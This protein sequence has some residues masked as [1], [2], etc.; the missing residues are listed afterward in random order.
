MERFRKIKFQNFVML[1]SLCLIVVF[2]LAAAL[3]LVNIR[4]DVPEQMR[5]YYVSVDGVSITEQ[6]LNIPWGELDRRVVT[7]Q[8]LHSFWPP[9]IWR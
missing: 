6:G 4:I 8:E 9:I 5:G 1:Y 2:I 7:E 3:F